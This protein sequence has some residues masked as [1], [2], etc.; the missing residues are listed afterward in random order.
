M[1]QDILFRNNVTVKGSGAQSLL[2]APGFGCDQSVWKTVSKSFED[3][4]QVILLDYVGTGNSDLRAYDA[5]KYSS[6]DGYAQDV[7]DVCSALNL[8]DTI[9]VGHSVGSMIGMLASLR[10]PD[11]F[12]KL[13]MLG[14]SPCYLNMPPDYYGGFEKQDLLGLIDMMEKNYIGWATVFAATVLNNPD[15]PELKD[16]LEERFC[17]TDPI[18]ARQFAEATFFADNRKDLSKVTAPSLILQCSEDIIA[19]DAVGQYLH[20]HLPYSTLTK[21]KAT[22]HCPHMSHPTE[23]ID[24]IR[25]YLQENTLGGIQRDKGTMLNG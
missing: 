25:H 18:I 19:P 23:T 15:R 24:C 8:K 21:M 10:H 11:Y 13:I 1:N 22:G 17:S 3:D 5:K 4:Y 12:S 14:P 16:E 9:F 20:Q 2:F 6:L 7:L